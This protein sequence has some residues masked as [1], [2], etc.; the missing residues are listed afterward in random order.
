MA[1]VFLFPI[2][3]NAQSIGGVQRRAPTRMRLDVLMQAADNMEQRHYDGLE[4][5][6]NLILKLSSIRL[7]SMDEPW[8]RDYINKIKQKIDEKTQNGNYSNAYSYISML[9][10][11][12]LS[13]P[14]L[15]SRHMA[16]EL[17]L[18]WRKKAEIQYDKTDVSELSSILKD[19]IS[20][21]CDGRPSAEYILKE[22]RNNTELGSFLFSYSLI[23]L[24]NVNGYKDWL[25]LVYLS[26]ECGYSEAISLANELQIKKFPNMMDG[27]NTK[28]FEIKDDNAIRSKVWTG[29]GFALKKGYIMSNYHVVEGASK[30]QVYGL[31]GD[32]IKACDATIVGIDKSNDL[33][34]LKLSG[35]LPTNLNNIPYGFRTTIADVGEDVYALGYPLL[36]TM[37]EEVKLTNG[38]VSSKTGYDGDVSQYQISVPVQ[39]GNSGGPLIDKNGNIVGVICA[40]HTGAENVTY[41]IKTSQVKILI[42]SISDLSLMNTVN[43]LKGKTLTEQ[44]KKIS[45][46]VFIIKCSK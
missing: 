20:I 43:T 5:R 25:Y 23:C 17:Y 21:K 37:G 11:D 27:H 29:T 3:M 10:T 36:A 33:A 12:A 9:S 7:N 40:K 28:L 6:N 44:V 45:N 13:D 4:L 46:Y 35:N 18:E 16:N 34:L 22:R 31:G 8:R 42:E 19:S 1:L 15:L 39:P 30:I 24:L 26:S 32:F 14:E 2:I 38:I 41:A